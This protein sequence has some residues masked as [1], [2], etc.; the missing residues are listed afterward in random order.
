V[1]WG[2]SESGY[3]AFDPRMNYQYR[4]FGVPGLGL[5]RGLAQDLVIAP[6]ATVLALMVAPAEAC[7]NLQRMSAEGFEGELGFFEAIDYT[8][9]RL[10]RGQPHAI[11][12]QLM[13]HHQ[14][15][16]LLALAH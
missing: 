3:H 16:S 13:A 15:M 6:Y 11:V 7:A 9:S 4:A 8:A 2:I 12:R 10:P 1:P 14:G 5:R